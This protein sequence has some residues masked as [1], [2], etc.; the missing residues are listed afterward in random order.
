MFLCPSWTVCLAVSRRVSPLVGLSVG[1]VYLPL[2]DV[3][4][5]NPSHGLDKL[6]V[7]F[8]TFFFFFIYVVSLLMS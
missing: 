5:L 2:P 8:V 3:L 4:A 7:H 1:A 6:G